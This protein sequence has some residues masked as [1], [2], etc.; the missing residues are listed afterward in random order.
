MVATTEAFYGD[1]GA[2]RSA[3]CRHP[4]GRHSDAALRRRHA[5]DPAAQMRYP[6]DRPVPTSRVA[7]RRQPEDC[8]RHAPWAA[9]A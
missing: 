9:Y 7:C 2:T 8:L 1:Q 4:G 5:V 3:T 6:A